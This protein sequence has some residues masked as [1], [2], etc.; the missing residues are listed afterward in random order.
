MEQE[1]ISQELEEKNETEAV[2]ENEIDRAKKK[3]RELIFEFSLFFVLGVLLGVTMKTEAVKKITIGFNDYQ[4]ESGKQRYD[5]GAM[6][7]DLQQKAIEQQNE[8]EK[9][10]TQQ[11]GNQNQQQ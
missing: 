3:R 4:I 9:Q 5:I 1:N 11:A 7:R 6:K 2:V 10:A 8:I